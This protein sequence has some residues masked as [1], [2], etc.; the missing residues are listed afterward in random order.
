MIKVSINLLVL[1]G[2]RGVIYTNIFV[3]THVHVQCTYIHRHEYNVH[4]QCMYI[5][6]VNVYIHV[7]HD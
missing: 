7:L 6:H 2:S 5:V 3:D 1:L 4:V